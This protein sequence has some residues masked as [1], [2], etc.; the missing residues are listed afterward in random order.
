FEADG[1]V[2]AVAAADP[3]FLLPAPPE[4][5]VRLALESRGR[6]AAAERDAQGMRLRVLLPIGNAYAG[7]RV[8]QGVFGLPPEYAGLAQRVET[9]VHGHRQA[10]FLR[11]A[12]KLAFAL[13]LSFV[14]LLSLLLAVL[15]A[16]DLA[17]RLVAPIARLA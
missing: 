12:L 1:R 8:L 2:R 10:M 3:A 13:I 17:R 14:L 16:F 5:D 6:Y 4:E 15:L 9:A 11:D 7:Q